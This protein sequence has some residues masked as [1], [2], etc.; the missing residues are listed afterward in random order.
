M[1]ISWGSIGVMWNKPFIQVVVRPTR[2]TY[3]FMQEYSDFTVCTFPEAYRKSLQLLGS[4][5][6]RDSDKIAASGISPCKSSIVR[7]P[8]YLEANLVIECRKIYSDE[9]RPQAF[10]D[11]SI[12]NLYSKNDYHTIYYGEILAI[13]GDRTLYT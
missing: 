7:A 8:A 12:D 1:T 6:G 2:Y 5:S 10:L 11:P 3:G 4:K 13:T 9:F